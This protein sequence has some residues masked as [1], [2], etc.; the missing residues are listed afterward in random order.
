MI[1]FISL[2]ISYNTNNT[3]HYHTFLTG[4]INWL[5]KPL[6]DGTDIHL[7]FKIENCRLDCKIFERGKDLT[8]PDLPTS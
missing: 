2:A 5:I 8:C 4:N 6:L 3:A 7:F 1:T